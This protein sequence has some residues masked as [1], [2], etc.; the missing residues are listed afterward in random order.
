MKK[1]IKVIGKTLNGHGDEVWYNPDSEMIICHK[2]MI[3]IYNVKTIEQ[4]Y[5]VAERNLKSFKR[6]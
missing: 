6:A 3:Y 5:E 4:A 1:N 2:A